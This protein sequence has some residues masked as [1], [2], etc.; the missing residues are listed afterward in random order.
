MKQ[1]ELWN[2]AVPA[3][4]AVEV[5]LGVPGPLT[6]AELGRLLGRRV[7]RSVALVITDNRSTML[8][9][10]EVQGELRLRLHRMFLEAS[11]EV[12][13]ALGGWLARGDRR[14]G[15]TLDAFIKSRPQEPPLRAVVC[16][17]KGRFHDLQVIWSELNATYFHGASRA[18]ITWGQGGGRRYRRT[19]QLGCYLL[20]DGLIRIHPALDQAFV[21]RH[22]VSWIVFHEMLHEVFGVEERGGRRCVHPPELLAVEQSYP[23]YPACKTWEAQNIHRLLRFR[24]GR[25]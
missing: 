20:S 21:P 8:S 2:N 7:G 25:S 24:T 12:L 13:E 19:I 17:P 6:A 1:L 9:Y 5:P 4:G 16:R 14:A 23:D 3:A 10:R 18:R 15:R 22:Y 11:P